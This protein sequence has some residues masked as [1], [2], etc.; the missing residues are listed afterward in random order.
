MASSNRSL[1]VEI[2]RDCL[3]EAIDELGFET[4]QS[5]GKRGEL[6]VDI[7]L[8]SS[9]NIIRVFTSIEFDDLPSDKFTSEG[10]KLFIC[11][12][13]KLTEKTFTSKMGLAL[14]R[15]GPKE[16]GAEWRRTKSW[17]AK[18]KKNVQYLVDLAERKKALPCPKCYNPMVVKKRSDKQKF[19]GCASFP[20]CKFSCDLPEGYEDNV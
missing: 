16:D 4:K 10:M 11:S 1:P 19:L 14:S 18:F 2:P 3:L 20:S 6:I 9:M 8:P 13:S 7:F 12:H 17:L 5:M 15:T